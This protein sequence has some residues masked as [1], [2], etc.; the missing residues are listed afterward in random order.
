[1]LNWNDIEQMLISG[2][3]RQ[4]KLYLEY[5]EAKNDVPKAVWESYSAFANQSGGFILLGVAEKPNLHISGVNNP[6]QIQDLLFSQCRSVEKVSCALLN[7]DDVRQFEIQ[8]KTVI[9]VYVRK[10]EATQRPVHLNQ[11][12]RRS[13]IRLNTGDHKLNDSE[14]RSFLSSYTHK[15]FDGH[16]LP[17]GTLDHLN[18][19]TLNKYRHLLK[20]HNPSSPLLTLSDE[21]FA[22]KTGIFSTD[23]TAGK[24]GITHAALLLF[25]RGEIIK[26]VFPHFFFEYIEKSEENHRYDLRITDFDLEDG[27]LF[28]FYLKIEPKITALGK[29]THFKLDKLTRT[30]ENEITEALRE[31]LVNAIAHA[32]YFNNVRHLKIVKTTNQI[33]FE[34]AGIMLVEIEQAILGNRSECRNG[35]IH[36][37]LRRIG[38]CERQ[39]EGVRDIFTH[40]KSRYFNIPKLESHI[41]HTKLTLT[42]Q[43]G[44]IAK[45]QEKLTACLGNDFLKLKEISKD[46]LLYIAV[47]GQQASH[48]QMADKMPQYSSRAITLALA[49]LKNKGL[50]SVSGE[51]RNDR[52][53]HLS[54]V[55]TNK[56]KCDYVDNSLIAQDKTLENQ[57]VNKK[58]LISDV[59]DNDLTDPVSV[60]VKQDNNLTDPVSEQV[61]LLLNVLNNQEMGTKALMGHLDLLHRQ[62][63]KNNYIKPALTLGL[64][65]ITIPN[66]P[67]SRNQKYRLTQSGKQLLTKLREK[68]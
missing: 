40:W 53:Y 1:M 49:Q 19:E 12:Y 52:V 41:D 26:G 45:W 23:A 20:A 67:T 5:K 17:Y 43:D 31:A 60:P 13:F 64:I 21:R 29:D 24:Q 44:E 11:D 22:E 47:N 37:L 9:A 34:N 65:E 15:D 62:T 39:G 51:K 61:A 6:T 4:E 14:L 18:R 50:L 59:Q 33:S 30:E 68:Q 58:P 10:A 42:F 32:D 28:E 2:N 54:Y 38:L 35:K 48:K 55:I 27:N 16:I 66:K 8:G 7:S 25:G 57:S 56:S 3:L 36:D 46:C 63:F